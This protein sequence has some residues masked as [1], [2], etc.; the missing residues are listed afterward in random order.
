V[1][2]SGA[3]LTVG[4]GTLGAIYAI[5]THAA[6]RSVGEAETKLAEYAKMLS[7]PGW[8][9]QPS[10]VCNPSVEAGLSDFCQEYKDDVQR[11]H[12][13]RRVRDIA[14]VSAGVLGVATVATF[15]IWRPRQAP[16]VSLTPVLNPAAPGVVLFANF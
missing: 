1:L 13:D 6:E 8:E 11:Q 16:A 14:F 5:R 7:M 2:L 15:F 9:I 3:A 10:Q 4:A 12:A